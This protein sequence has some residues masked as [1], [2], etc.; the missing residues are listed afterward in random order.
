MHACT[1]AGT[2]SAAPVKRWPYSSVAST[3]ASTPT[4]ADISR[5]TVQQSTL[6]TISNQV[7]FTTSC[8]PNRVC[9]KE[10]TKCGAT[11]L[12]AH[13]LLANRRYTRWLGGRGALCTPKR[14]TRL[15]RRMI[16]V[17]RTSESETARNRRHGSCLATLEV[18]G[19]RRAKRA[20][21]L[22]AGP[23][24][25]YHVPSAQSCTYR[26]IHDVRSD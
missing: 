16:C 21:T 18:V 23:Q 19:R 2:F 13:T 22:Q 9:I 3:T 8:L 11:T 4:P 17:V 10:D 24:V 14:L 15:R 5:C 25:I 7:P 26:R 1:H 20:V 6:S 12:A